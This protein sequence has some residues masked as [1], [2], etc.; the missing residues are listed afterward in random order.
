MKKLSLPFLLLILVFGVSGCDKGV[1]NE[2]SSGSEQ[3][4]V[5]DDAVMEEDLSEE[6]TFDVRVA[7]FNEA[8][9][10]A[11]LSTGQEKAEEALKSSED[12][13]NL[14]IGIFNDFVNNQPQ[15]YKETTD[16]VERMKSLSTLIITSNDMVKE[17]EFKEAHE[18]LEMVRKKMREIREENNIRNISD[19]MLTFHDVMEEVAEAET[20]AEIDDKMVDL[21]IN[22]T[23]LKDYN[24]GDEKYEE[25]LKKLEN[26]ISEVD[27]S[28]E[29]T[30]IEKRDKLKPAFIELYMMFG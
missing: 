9:K 12:A 14:W 3:A 2:L 30:F 1:E 25:K 18:K 7:E 26:V 19:D 17:G 15:E 22:F 6:K 20:R 13:N 16:W 4:E 27:N 10:K 24:E 29:S 28:D 8:Y 5:V 11:L 21:K 23:V